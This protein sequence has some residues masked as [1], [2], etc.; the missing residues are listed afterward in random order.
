MYNVLA[1]TNRR[2]CKNN[3]LDQIKNICLLNDKIRERK[4]DYKSYDNLSNINSI[5][6]VLREKDLNEKDYKSLALKVMKICREYQ[7]DC[8]LHTYYKTA[9]ELDCSKIHLPLHVINDNPK[10]INDFHTVGASI[11]SI[12]EAIIADNLGV[13]YLTAGHIFN[14]DCKKG[15]PGRG[16]V[17]LNNIVSSVNIPVYAI[18]GICSSNINQVIKT[19][20]KGVCIMSGLMEINNPVEFF[21]PKD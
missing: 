16:L 15:I 7:T 4:F 11:H 12:E 6:I 9:L 1:I 21:Q 18:G 13:D 20:A 5:S 2:L 17:F 3:F 10:I 8:I 19:G 14:T